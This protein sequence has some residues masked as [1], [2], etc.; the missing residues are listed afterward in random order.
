MKRYSSLPTKVM[1]LIITVA[2]ANLGNNIIAP[3]LPEIQREFDSTAA[4]M[5][6]IASG[7]GMGRLVMDLPTGYL[8]DRVSPVKLFTVGIVITAGSAALASTATSLEQLILFRTGMG[9][10]SAIMHCVTLVML[11]GVARPD[12]RGLVLSFFTSA[13]L[14]GQ[15]ISPSIG[16]YLGTLF[17][18]R[19]AFV[20]CALTPLATLPLNFLLTSRVSKTSTRASKH[21]HSDEGSPVNMGKWGTRANRV[22]L[23]S[24]FASTFANFFNRH[25][26]RGNL[27]PLYAG[28]VLGMNVGAIGAVLTVASI[29]TIIATLPA[30]SL[31]DRK[32]KK[33]LLIP[34]LSTLIVGN[35][36]LLVP[37]GG[38]WVFVLSTVFVS[39]GVLANSM[40]SSLVADLTPD[41]VLGKSM[42]IYRF[43]ADL[44]VV[45]GPVALGMV[46]DNFGFPAAALAGA[47]V[48]A[49]AVAV[50]TVLI[51]RD[52]RPSPAEGVM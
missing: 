52:T 16:G 1:A 12:Q 24:V 39:M 26:M 21:R 13:M 40:Q 46:A 41:A 30:G 20:F 3:V 28:M 14:G 2:I 36:F 8:S 35:M 15:A 11:V 5:G 29:I 25:G 22:A 38:E 32:G 51:P 33:L 6:L 27:L 18:W 47:G 37:G 17:D 4:A 49:I 19:A 34:G 43:T 7:F 50:S 42:G 10:G 31:A 23:W 45:L 9:V 44:G 48:V